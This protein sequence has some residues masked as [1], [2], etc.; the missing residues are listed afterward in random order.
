MDNKKDET[1]E[2]NDEHCGG[3]GCGCD[4]DDHDHEVDGFDFEDMDENDIIYLTLDDDTELEC[5]VLGI[6]EVED[7]EYIALLPM[8]DDEVLLYRYVELE[9][10]EFDLLPIENEEEFGTVSEA[11]EALFIDDEDFV[12]YENYDELDDEE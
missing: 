2:Y 3:C 10:N 1:F 8:G 5:N 12:E 4:C 7:V 11:F 9:D 6:F